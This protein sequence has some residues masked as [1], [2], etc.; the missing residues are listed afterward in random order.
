MKHLKT[1]VLA[2]CLVGA[3]TSFAGAKDVK[4]LA[5][6]MAVPNTVTV[7]TASTTDS[8]DIIKDL[9]IK[10]NAKPTTINGPVKVMRMH[11]LRLTIWA[12]P[13]MYINYKG[14]IKPAKGRFVRAVDLKRQP[15][16]C[17]ITLRLMRLSFL[18]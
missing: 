13:M 5:G 6:T 9:L 4:T 12:F 10:D 11:Y 17:L 2:A 14:K 8:L 18:Y 1:F 15:M 7:A 16:H 3:V